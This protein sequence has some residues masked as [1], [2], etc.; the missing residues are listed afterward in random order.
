MAIGKM[1]EQ[2][3]SSR[4]LLVE[5]AKKPAEPKLKEVKK[6]TLSKPVST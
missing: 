4:V 2:L 3:K 5:S 1:P 6:T